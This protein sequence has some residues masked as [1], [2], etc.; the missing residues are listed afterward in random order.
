MKPRNGTSLP[1]KLFNRVITVVVAGALTLLFFLVLPII[2]TINEAMKDDKYTVST[3]DT[4]A[5]EPPPDMPDPPEPPEEEPE[6][7]PEPELD[8]PQ[9]RLADLTEFSD[10]LSGVGDGVGIGQGFAPPEINTEQLAAAGMEGGLGMAELDQK[11]RP[12]SQASPRIPPQMRGRGGK[13]YVVFDVNKRG[14][15]E[16]AIVERATHPLL[17]APALQAVRKWTFEPG[18]RAGQPARFRMR[19]PIVFPK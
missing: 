13:V 8:Q 10:M 12:I 2:Q 16:N 6:S 7:E 9:Q 3:P 18:K 15:V 4:P 11:P 14:R 19:V 1:R 17:E 5:P